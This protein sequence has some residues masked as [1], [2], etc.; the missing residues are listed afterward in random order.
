M[1]S[2]MTTSTPLAW[3]ADDHGTLILRPHAQDPTAYVYL[4]GRRPYC[5]RGHWE[6]GC[7]GILADHTQ[8]PSY[9]FMRLETAR[10]EVEAW[11]GRL[12]GLPYKGHTLIDLPTP[13]EAPFEQEPG[14][15]L[16]WEWKS[17]AGSRMVHAHVTDPNTGA[18]VVL[19]I[20]ENAGLHGPVW[21]VT[22]EGLANVDASDRFPRVYMSLAHAQE[23][24][25][26]FLAW[27]LL[28]AA[29]EHPHR[30]TSSEEAAVSPAIAQALGSLVEADGNPVVRRRGPRA[31]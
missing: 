3:Q 13:W 30:L 25:E 7:S 8:A 14:R 12:A 2:P 27:R 4:Q 18:A 17:G 26:A 29:C 24:T 23:E 22:Q 1:I 15:S 16:G 10:Q 9:Y 11:L 20:T 5:D 28:E 21:T 19:T 6:W 31:K